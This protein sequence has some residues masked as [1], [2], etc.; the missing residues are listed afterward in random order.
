M[1]RKIL[2]FLLVLVLG[3]SLACPAFAASSFPDVGENASYSEAVDF[4]KEIGI[5]QG[6]STGNFNP[7]K[8]VSRAEM[9]AIL[10]RMLGETSDLTTSTQ[11]SD[12]PLDY[13]AN[14]YISKVAELGVVGG[15]GNGKF[16]P[17]DIVTYEQAVTMLL[18]AL[19]YEN[20]AE[21]AGGYPNGYMAVA[22]DIDILDGL[23][24]ELGEPLNRCDVAVILFN[25]YH[26]Y[27]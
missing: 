4:L 14:A 9:A 25:S 5:M 12:V 19:G 21:E 1:M 15:Y 23:D 27:T 13:W 20:E 8:A 2:C 7:N 26:S 24:R 16:G 10:C 6:D 11:F 18:R 22:R 17:S 3:G